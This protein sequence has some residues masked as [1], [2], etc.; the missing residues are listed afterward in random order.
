MLIQTFLTEIL[1]HLYSFDNKFIRKFVLKYTAKIENGEPYSPHYEKY[2]QTTIILKLECTVM[3]VVLYGDKFL[4]AQKLADTVLSPTKYIS[5]VVTI[6]LK[7]NQCT[8]FF[9]IQYSD[10]LKRI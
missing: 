9:I 4:R 10:M 5:S 1:Y 8:H 2:F 7:E 6:H 3:E